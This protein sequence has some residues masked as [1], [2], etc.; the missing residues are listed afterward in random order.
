MHTYHIHMNIMKIHIVISRATTKSCVKRD[1]QKANKMNKIEYFL[2]YMI[3]T[4]ESWKG[5]TMEQ[6]PGE[7]NIRQTAKQQTKIKPFQ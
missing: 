6:I 1:S 4:K 5:G 2:K 7:T 3:N